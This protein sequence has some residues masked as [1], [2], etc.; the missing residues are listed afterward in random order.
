[1]SLKE[2]LHSGDNLQD[3]TGDRSLGK[4]VCESCSELHINQGCL[5]MHTS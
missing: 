1:M 3:I 2:T 5:A 4:K